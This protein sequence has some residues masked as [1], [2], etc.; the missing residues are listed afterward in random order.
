MLVNVED[1][2]VLNDDA[3]LE[4]L[5]DWE[6]ED[7]EMG[8]GRDE[9]GVGLTDVEEVFKDVGLREEEEGLMRDD[10]DLG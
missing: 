3:D 1:L 4:E 9:V 5:L 10:E 6:D 2:D 7:L 8:E